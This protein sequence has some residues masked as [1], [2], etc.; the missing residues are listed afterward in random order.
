MRLVTGFAGPHRLRQL[1]DAVMA[2]ASELDLPTVLQR[3]TQSAVDLVDAR[4]G[5]LGVLDETG[6]R[7]SQFITIGIDDAGRAA[8]GALPEGHGI[9]GHLIVDARPLRLPD[10]TEHP[11]S[12]GFPPGHPPM[13]SFLGVPI[14]VRETVFGNLY[15]TDKTSA[16][17][18]TDVD[19]EMVVGLAGAAG[20]AIENAR[21]SAR[22]R[23]LAL[24]E[25]RER[26]ARDL[27]DS[28]IQRLFATGMSLQSTY[29]LVRSD[30]DSAE[31]RIDRAV[32][33]LDVTIR[34]IRT[35]IF[36]L[37]QRRATSTGLRSAL[38]A[39]AR[40]AAGAM[41]FEPRLILDGPIDTAVPGPIGESL[42]AVV[43]EALSNVAR[44][45]H[46]TTAAVEL[47]V[48]EEVVLKIV[49]DGVG[50]AADRPTGNGLRNLRERAVRLGGTAEL[51][52]GDGGGTTVEWRVPLPN[53]PD[54]S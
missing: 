46:A 28:V 42:L 51:A 48:A 12:Y 37:E 2:I 45:A 4:Y 47:R 34:E 6:T 29:R 31:R 21:L 5:A 7:L 52:S 3:I 23:D 20:I 1:L 27:H 32:D 9:L 49:D 30:P 26:I 19:E 54:R 50:P 16:E 25:D 43:R 38:L 44:H 13:H 33:D 39:T 14:R 35:A 22:V 40:E 10:L 41:G 11:E 36:G 15:L 18:F 17:V 8:I 24:A 53:V